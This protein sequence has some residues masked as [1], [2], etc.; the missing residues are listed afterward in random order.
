M[1]IHRFLLRDP[2]KVVD[3]VPRLRDRSMFYFVAP[4]AFGV[5]LGIARRSARSTYTRGF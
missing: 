5:I 3:R 1:M 2:A 4:N